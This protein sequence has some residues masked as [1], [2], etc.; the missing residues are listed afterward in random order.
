MGR[1]RRR[2]ERRKEEEKSREH[3]GGVV[4]ALTWVS[5]RSYRESGGHCGPTLPAVN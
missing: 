3:G 4:F 5:S 1:D 2:E